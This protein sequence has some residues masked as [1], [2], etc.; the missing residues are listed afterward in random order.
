MSFYWQ[1]KFSIARIILWYVDLNL[2]SIMTFQKTA[3]KRRI[4][5]DET[6]KNSDHDEFLLANNM[7]N[8][9]DNSVVC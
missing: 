8:F 6:S 7:F 3:A 9:E 1:V 5:K 2:A 4:L